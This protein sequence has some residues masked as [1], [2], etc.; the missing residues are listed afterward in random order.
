MLADLRHL[1]GLDAI[2]ISGDIANDGS[3]EA[4]LATRDLLRE[5]A[6]ERNVP[7]FCSTGNH[8]ERQAFA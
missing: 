3:L 5:F 6:T 1:R 8:D 2:V 7:V 4:Y